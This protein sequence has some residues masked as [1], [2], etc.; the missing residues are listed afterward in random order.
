MG[1]AAKIV[2]SALI[3]GLIAALGALMAVIT[4]MAPDASIS[5]IG[6]ITILTIVITG[7]LTA[8]KD[9]QAYLKNHT[10]DP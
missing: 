6:S 1:Q 5:D 4:N 7:I 2:I 10:E 8:A 9:A 3:N